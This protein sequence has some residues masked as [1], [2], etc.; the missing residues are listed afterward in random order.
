PII[1]VLVPGGEWRTATLNAGPVKFMVGDFAGAIIDFLII[2]FVV[3]M[4]VKAIMK[5]DAT[6]KR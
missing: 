4:I 5:E 2:A 6:A 1:A 3:F